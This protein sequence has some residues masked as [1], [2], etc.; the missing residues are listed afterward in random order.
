MIGLS[1]Y[2]MGRDVAYASEL[3]DTLRANA[4]ITVDRVNALLAKF[5]AEREVTSGWRPAL[6]NATTPGA[7][8]HSKHMTCQACDLEDHDGNLDDWAL[9]NPILDLIGLWQ[10]FPGSTKGWF[11]CQIV[12]YAS[13]V[14]GKRR[15]FYP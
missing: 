8:Q 1:D 15:W 2:Y 13:W 11:H 10:E 12:P 6:V 14:P 3:T 5:G 9:D 4:Q 7:A